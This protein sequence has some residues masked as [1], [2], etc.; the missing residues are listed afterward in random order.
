MESLQTTPTTAPALLPESIRGHA[1]VV[2]MRDWL[3]AHAPWR[4]PV[5]RAVARRI[6]AA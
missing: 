1:Q 3:A 4:V 6:R 2:N 5:S